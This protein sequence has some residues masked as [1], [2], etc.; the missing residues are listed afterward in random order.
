MREGLEYGLAPLWVDAGQRVEMRKHTGLFRSAVETRSDGGPVDPCAGRGRGE[1]SA[2]DL[3]FRP[4]RCASK[5]SCF[6]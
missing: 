4:G 6:R 5:L 3:R 2:W 1:G